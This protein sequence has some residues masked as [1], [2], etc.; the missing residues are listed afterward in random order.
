[1]E[2]LEPAVSAEELNAFFASLF[3]KRKGMPRHVEASYGKVRIELDC[4][5]RHL[6]PPD[7]IN[8]PTQMAIADQA[9]YSAVFTLVG[10]KPMALTSNLNI[11]FLRPCRGDVLVADAEVMKQG[12]A[13]TLIEV[14]LRGLGQD[15]PASHALVTY[16]VPTD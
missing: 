10:I 9:A 1:M 14:S 2:E 5:E 3:P 7:F 11:N 8:G 15:K 12:R 16:V 6:R 13:G 4:N